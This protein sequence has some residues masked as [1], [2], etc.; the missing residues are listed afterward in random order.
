MTILHYIQTSE[1]G[2]FLILSVK[3]SLLLTSALLICRLLKSASASTRHFFMSA[4]LLLIMLLP[5][6]SAALPTIELFTF[7][8]TI[9]RV[10]VQPISPGGE[11]VASLTPQVGASDRS[12]RRPFPPGDTN[13]RPL[14]LNTVIALYVFGV[15]FLLLRLLSA[16]FWMWWLRRGAT[17]LSRCDEHLAAVEVEVA[18]SLRIRARYSVLCSARLTIPIVSGWIRPTILLPADAS[19]WSAAQARSVF[20]H[21]F[22]HIKRSDSLV[23]M[24]LHLVSAWQWFNPLVWIVLR[25]CTIDREKACDDCALTAGIPGPDY[26]RYLITVCKSAARARWLAATGLAMAAPRSLERRLHS[27]LDQTAN[28]SLATIGGKIAHFL[29]LLFLVLPVAT[30]SGQAQEL[31]AQSASAIQQG[32]VRQT[33]QG[34]LDALS[35]GA[36]FDS[37]CRTYLASDYFDRSELTMENRDRSEWDDVR[38][39]MFASLQSRKILFHPVV[40]GAINGVSRDNDTFNVSLLMNVFND[41]EP[42]SGVYFTR[43]LICAVK[44]VRENGAFKISSI[45]GGLSFMRMDINNPHG[46]IFLVWTEDKGDRITPYGPFI[47]KIIPESIRQEDMYTLYLE[48]EE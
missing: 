35:E 43:D 30:I 24:L 14:L 9:T 15:V 40:T 17:S 11:S 33:L 32:D 29:L 8:A 27:I 4:A 10:T 34:F 1:V 23:S 45:D 46:P 31:I 48:L 3:V 36:D 38:K 42:D 7:P 18:R 6:V 21:E 41:A 22:A 47:I 19:R 12:E 28:R 13:T 25:Q 26:A 16:Q 39:K 20:L 44:L 2:W 37:V 5:L